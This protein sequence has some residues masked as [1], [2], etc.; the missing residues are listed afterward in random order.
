[1]TM[2]TLAEVRDWL[3]TFHAAQQYYIGKLDNKELYS[4]GVYQRKNVGAP[5]RAIGGWNQ[6]SYDVKEV[7]ILIHH[8]Q[9]A[10]ETEKRA[11][12]LYNQILHSE[13]VSIGDS[14]IQLIELLT[15]EPVDVGCDDNHVY[16]RVIE[17]N[18]YYKRK[19]E[20]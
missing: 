8:N 2:I 20:D 19:E 12:Y 17:M 4:I 5:R 14:P 10:N 15:N 16:E 9:N 6:T 7:T 18:L 13:S 1:M 3:K 11:Q